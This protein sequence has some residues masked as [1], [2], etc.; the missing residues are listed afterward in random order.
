MKKILAASVITLSSVS[1][2]ASFDCSK[3]FD[4]S[5]RT[6]CASAIL[7]AKDDALAHDYQQA[8]AATGNSPAFQ[9]L[10]KQN[11]LNRKTCKTVAC[12]SDWYAHSSKLYR[13]IS[14]KNAK[15]CVHE[16]Q[17][18]R[19]TGTLLQITYAGPPNYESIE[20]GDEPETYWVLQPDSKIRCA[21]DS[22]AFDDYSKMQLVVNETAYRD[23]RSLVAHHV[24][25]E[26]RLMYAI[27]GH[28]HTSLLIQVTKIS[29]AN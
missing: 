21:Q 29:A 25:V 16:G 26:G 24:M 1:H 23:Y 13:S 11:W 5:E 19:L 14:Q 18:V 7:S 8:K 4:Y 2:A 10:V 17:Q 22:Y 28:H 12:L 27:T 6:I 3:A 9:K 20:Q 15:S